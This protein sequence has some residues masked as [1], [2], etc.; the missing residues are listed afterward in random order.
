VANPDVLAVDHAI[1]ICGSGPIRRWARWWNRPPEL[2]HRFGCWYCRW[3]GAGARGATESR[4]G[5]LIGWRS[6]AA[7]LGTG[8]E[9]SK[10]ERHLIHCC[11]QRYLNLGMG[12]LVPYM[13]I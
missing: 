10:T 6:L 5:G 2:V 4:A 13:V 11:R 9:Y 12:E 3:S 1:R 8:A 7:P